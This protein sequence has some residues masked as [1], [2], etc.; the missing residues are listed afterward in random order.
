MLKPHNP[1]ARPPR[2]RIQ[3]SGG[4]GTTK[5]LALLALALLAALSALAVDLAPSRAQTVWGTVPATVTIDE[6]NILGSLDVRSYFLV[7]ATVRDAND[8]LVQGAYANGN[9]IPSVGSP[10][11]SAT[12]GDTRAASLINGLSVFQGQAY[13]TYLV[14]R[15]GPVTITVTVAG[16]SDSITLQLGEPADSR[17]PEPSSILLASPLDLRWAATNPNQ[18]TVTALVTDA[19]G[20]TVPDGTPVE[21]KLWRFR[22]SPVPVD[23]EGRL[24]A[25]I[26][27]DRT[28]TNGAVTGTW[29]RTSTNAEENPVLVVARAGPAVG[30]VVTEANRAL[31]AAPKPTAIEIFEHPER[32]ESLA[33]G[34]SVTLRARLTDRNGALVSN[35]EAV[36]W[37]WHEEGR[38]LALGREDVFANTPTGGVNNA[39]TTNGVASATFT[40]RYPG[41]VWIRAYEISG[42][43]DRYLL[44]VVAFNVGDYRPPPDDLTLN[45]RL[46]DDSDA[47]VPTG[48]TLRVGADLTYSGYG[49]IDQA[50]HVTS[51]ALRIVGSLQWE[52]GRNRLDAPGQSALTRRTVLREHFAW[53]TGQVGRGAQG[54]R[55]DG[56]CKGVSEDGETNWTC[57]LDLGD[58][59][60]ITIP[61]GTPAG[62]YT[63]SAALSI[64]GRQYTDTMEFTIVEPGSIDE[65]AEVRL[66]FAPQERGP[67]RGDPYPSAI[68]PGQSTKLRLTSLNEH[69]A[70]SATGSI[71]S[72]LL[73]AAA[74]TLSTSLGDGCAPAGGRIC[75]IPVSA[76]TASN[77]HQIPITITHPGP[78]K[79]GTTTVEATLISSDGEA[80]TPPPLTITFKGAAA[81]LAIS[82]PPTGLLG[83]ATDN[84]DRDQLKLTVT[85]ADAAGNDVELPY[86]APR[87][88]IKNADGNQITSGISVVWTEDGPDDDETH[89]RFARNAANAVEATITAT[90]AAAAPLTPGEYT[91]ELRT[92][93][94]T[95]TRKFTIVGPVRSV[96][97]GDP[98]GDLQVN[99][100]ITLTATIRDAEDALV[101]DGTPVEWNSLNAGETTVLVQLRAD[102]ST[103]NG[104]ATAQFWAVNPGT[105]TITA[106]ADNIADLAWVRIPTTPAAATA[107]AGAAGSGAAGTGADGAAGSGAGGA[108]GSAGSGS[109]GADGSA[110]SGSAGTGA[111]G[112]AADGA[113]GTGADGSGSAGAADG[114]A[115]GGAAATAPPLTSTLPGSF[116]TYIGA[117]PT[118]AAALL[119]DLP[120]VL[121]ISYWSGRGWSRYTGPRS[122][123]FPIPPNALLWLAN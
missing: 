28:T 102:R 22:N 54:G 34:E 104:A 32:W 106:R 115:A 76:V 97:L 45:L 17:P 75:R 11:W 111:A 116:S 1:R 7:R 88:T 68:A 42:G 70:A 20:A 91:L 60:A 79:A 71:A 30:A 117:A 103:T 37:R 4:G 101:P 120:G 5:R 49:E 21:W 24:W 90:A 62:T 26:S 113:A 81:S 110:G 55:A 51:G 65:V 25:P 10:A 93:N 119:N 52:A 112:S 23:E 89:D 14:I 18:V 58:S 19:N 66:D 12:D 96:A 50:L 83:S 13:A 40:A 98:Q 95:A 48:S 44:D 61:A 8:R 77:A 41:F 69:G 118:T 105:A 46:L 123:N 86:R 114:S 6:S 3:N 56:Q 73:T 64:N 72:I 121:S 109:A 33:V 92:D 9:P 53:H 35:E 38:A 87:A 94:K 16:V 31:Q 67:N 99:G 80:F 47:M 59:A 36:H 74:G 84:D 2:A 85:A 107:G 108:A 122:Q 43:S 82:E 63:I 29:R 78:N 27:V 100:T 39:L 57:P 15:P